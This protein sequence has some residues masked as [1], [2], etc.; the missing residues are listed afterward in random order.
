MLD[1]CAECGY[2]RSKVRI[3][4]LDKSM[5]DGFTL[6]KKISDAID[7]IPGKKTIL[8]TQT[9]R[10][11]YLVT[12]RSLYRFAKV[13]REL[14]V[15]NP[16][17]DEIVKTVNVTEEVKNKIKT[18]S[19]TDLTK[20][21]E[22]LRQK[23]ILKQKITYF[24][25]AQN[26]FVTQTKCF[27]FPYLLDGIR[28]GLA[29]GFRSQNIVDLKWSNID[30][31]E[32]YPDTI[33]NGVIKV[34]D[35]K[36][37]HQNKI[38]RDEAQKILRVRITMEIKNILEDLGYCKYKGSCSYVLAPTHKHKRETINKNLSKGFHHYLLEVNPDLDFAFKHLRKTCITLD[39][40]ANG[41]EGAS[42]RVH[43]DPRTTEGHYF[44]ENVLLPTARELESPPIFL[45]NELDEL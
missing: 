22:I 36:Y 19:Q 44:D 18:I 25:K 31:S 24:S 15:K 42:K 40:K 8:P 17:M 35:L 32:A 30:L 37:A 43:K 33:E 39:A 14:N 38:I 26:K 20:L 21:C 13:K 29:L 28:L 4:Q 3:D 23:K 10:N 5:A 1:V 11:D 7:K 41:K 45:D 34:F 27:Y 9:T 12:F 2:E 16:F 6:I